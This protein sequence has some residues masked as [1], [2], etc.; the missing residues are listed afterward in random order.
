MGLFGKEKTEKDYLKDIAKAQHAQVKSSRI[1]A[2][3][4]YEES[5]ARADVARA[6]AD[7][8]NDERHRQENAII[9]QEYEE[10]LHKLQMFYQSFDYD[11][12]DV[13]DIEQ[14]AIS[15]IYWLDMVDRSFNDDK[16][17]FRFGVGSETWGDNHIVDDDNKSKEQTLI[18][19]LHM[20]VERLN[21]LKIDEAR[22]EYVANKLKFYEDRQE[23]EAEA[24]RIRIEK[25]KAKRKKVW[26][27]L[28]IAFLIIGALV[29]LILIAGFI[30]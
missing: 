9:K 28:G 20:A 7:S 21:V 22:L 25:R 2:M 1:E 6:E 13:N 23:Q 10:C 19:K 5:R 4:A 3:G 12:N 27:R 26:K 18:K 16:S 15:I 30:L 29:S 14:K 11:P 8:I 17:E 24:E